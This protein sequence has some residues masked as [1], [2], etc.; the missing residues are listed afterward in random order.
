MEPVRKYTGVLRRPTSIRGTACVERNTLLVVG[1]NQAP[2][3]FSVEEPLD[4]RAGLMSAIFWCQVRR[5]TL[6]DRARAC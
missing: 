4:G 5:M 3:W 6:A 2:A 1:L